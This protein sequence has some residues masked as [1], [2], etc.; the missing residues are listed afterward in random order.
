MNTRWPRPRATIAG[1]S[2]AGERD[3]RAQVDLE[4]AVDLLLGQLGQRARC[5]AAPALATSTSTSPASST[6]PLDGLAVGEVA[7]ERAAAELGGERLEHV[8]AAAGEVEARAARGER[9][10]DR[11]ADAAGRAGQQDAAADEVTRR[12]CSRRLRPAARSAREDR[13]ASP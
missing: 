8:G 10:G 11:V 3:R 7:R 2:A 13:D 12:Q 4:H 6:Q 5:R 9:A 1:A